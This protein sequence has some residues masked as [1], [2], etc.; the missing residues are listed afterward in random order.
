MTFALQ[1]LLF[2]DPPGI[3]E[4]GIDLKIVREGL[5]W[6]KALYEGL[7]LLVFILS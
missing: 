7:P 4:A 3:S 1:D 6:E 2:L 5:S